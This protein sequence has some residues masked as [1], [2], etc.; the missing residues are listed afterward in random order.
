MNF[1]KVFDHG[2]IERRNSGQIYLKRKES[3][4]FVVLEI[5]GYSLEFIHKNILKN[6]FA[7][8]TIALMGKTFVW[9]ISIV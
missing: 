3:L 7:C 8:E 2:E 9:K 6:G 4:Y 1:P 5:T